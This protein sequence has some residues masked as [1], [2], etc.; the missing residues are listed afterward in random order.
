MFLIETTKIG[1]LMTYTFR[2]AFKA[3]LLLFV[4]LYGFNISFAQEDQVSLEEEIQEN[5][6][7]WNFLEEG[8]IK[9]DF[10]KNKDFGLPTMY[11]HFTG[12]SIKTESEE[13]KLI[14]FTSTCDS[15][16]AQILSNGSGS[17]I[18]HPTQTSIRSN[19]ILFSPDCKTAYLFPPVN[20]LLILNGRQR[21]GSTT[22]GLCRQ[23]ENKRNSVDM[24][25]NSLVKVQEKL[26]E[27]DLENTEES[28]KLVKRI[29]E[30]IEP[31]IEARR[32]KELLSLSELNNSRAASFGLTTVSG[33]NSDLIDNYAE[34]N[35]ELLNAI[36]D[37]QFKLA[38]IQRGTMFV[39]DQSE[40][41]SEN[42]NLNNVRDVLNVSIPGYISGLKES[43]CAG[44]TCSEQERN[45]QSQRIAESLNGNSPFRLI[46]TRAWICDNFYS[47]EIGISK[48]SAKDQTDAISSQ[49]SVT[50]SYGVAMS[51][52]FNIKATVKIDEVVKGVVK[53]L[54]EYEK[55]WTDEVVNFSSADIDLKNHTVLEIETPFVGMGVE[56]SEGYKEYLK[57]YEEQVWNHL[58][59]KVMEKLEEIKI[60]TD[61]SDIQN[62]GGPEDLTGTKRYR[63]EVR[64]RCKKKWYGSRKCWPVKV[65]IPYDAETRHAYMNSI[66]NKIKG[67][68]SFVISKDEVVTYGQNAIFM[69]KENLDQAVNY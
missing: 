63:T 64:Q 46:L 34:A 11:T 29:K 15:F 61:V 65:N 40:L 23:L 45:E 57:Q 35:Q 60:F 9:V 52:R 30:V 37:F 50:W 42:D 54:Q 33:F 25:K 10:K 7:S 28:L 21:F 17:V 8:S 22:E 51:T 18:K 27:A 5:N 41:N 12:M 2:T 44:G 24:V 20:N 14:E 62:V 47:P 3:I 48:Q 69:N 53:R 36:P 68:F 56:S 6:T 31:E 43:D 19:Q 26:Y 58:S 16:L 55:N 67:D 4:S 1:V 38:P 39:S 32:D 13:S 59:D 66:N 49:T